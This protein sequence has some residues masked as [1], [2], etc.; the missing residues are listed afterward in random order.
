MRRMMNSEMTA[1][2]V[3]TNKWYAT[4][5]TIKLGHALKRHQTKPYS[6]VLG[7]GRFERRSNQTD[8]VAHRVGDVN[9]PMTGAH[10][11]ML[12]GLDL[13]WNRIT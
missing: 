1:T 8:R 6:L 11:R 10:V 12:A 7:L 4:T 3:I 2:H 5:D 13:G 9:A